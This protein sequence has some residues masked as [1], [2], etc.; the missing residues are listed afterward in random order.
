MFSG[1]Y[2]GG[3]AEEVLRF[4]LRDGVFSK[5][6]SEN[7][8]N[9]FVIESKYIDGYLYFP[10]KDFKMLKLLE[11][12]DDSDRI[13]L[14]YLFDN[15]IERAAL[16]VSVVLASAILKSNKGIDP[17]HPVCITAEGSSF[18]KMKNFQSRVDS[19]M[20]RILGERGTYY[21]EIN[22]VENAVL[23]GAAAAGLIG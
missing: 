3:L 23:C 4:A 11:K 2:L 22:R 8:N 19:Y 12:M 9:S 13:K 17:C 16:L 10:P 20:Q 14:Y 7:F 21:Y 6:F 5:N 18:Y 15:L 1:A